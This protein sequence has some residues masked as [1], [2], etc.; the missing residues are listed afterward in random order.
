MPTVI[1]L[2]KVPPVPEKHSDQRDVTPS[3]SKSLPGKT[4]VVFLTVAVLIAL[5]CGL[6]VARVAILLIFAGILVAVVFD[7]LCGW[8]ETHT[9]LRRR[10][11]LPLMLIVIAALLWLGIWLRGPAIEDQIDQLHEKLPQAARTLMVQ[12]RSQQWGRWLLAHGFGAEQFPRA[13][14]IL[15]RVTGVLSTTLGFLAGIV[16]VLFLGIVMAAE[17][18]TYR[19]GFETFFPAA[20]RTYVNYVGNEIADALRWWLIARLVAMCGVGLM[21]S[22]GLWALGIPMAGTLGILAALLTFVPNVGP[23]LSAIPPVLLAFTNGPRQALFV[24]LLFWAVHA[25]EGLLITPIAERAAVHLPPGLTLSVQL[26]LA[27]LVGSI[28]IALA[29]PLTTVIVVLVRTVYR[30]KILKEDPAQPEQSAVG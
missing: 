12:V 11:A 28:G 5:L 14:D 20:N 4:V 3:I 6:W 21:V 10:W 9:R 25:I 26:V 18:R 23:V 1:E 7:T 16:I 29:A 15:P 22:L 8:I 2:K 17:P 13:M 30:Q 19:R 27:I 24:V